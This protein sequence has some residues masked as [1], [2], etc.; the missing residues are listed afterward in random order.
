VPDEEKRRLADFV[1]DTGCSMEQT[2]Q[3]VVELIRKLKDRQ[4][5]AAA[6]ALANA[7]QH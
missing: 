3:Q 6:R 4:G 2:Q 1:V 5:T 7:P